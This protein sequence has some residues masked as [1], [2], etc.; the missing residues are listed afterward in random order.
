M[1]SVDLSS[2]GELIVRVNDKEKLKLLKV[3]D[4]REP[5]S[6]AFR[7]W[8][9]CEYPVLPQ[10]TSHSW[11]V[12]SSS[13]LEKPRFVVIWFQTDRKNNLLNHSAYFDH[14]YLKNL[15]VYLNS[16]VYPYEDF[17]ADFSNN[18]ISIIYKA[19]TYIDMIR[20]I[21]LKL[22]L[23]SNPIFKNLLP[24]KSIPNILE[25]ISSL[26]FMGATY[27]YYDFLNMAALLCNDPAIANK[28]KH[29][30]DLKINTM[31][32]THRLILV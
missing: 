25:S 5:L 21:S 11:T 29:T 23:G 24:T 20:I 6:C 15:K 30:T 8:N 14:C 16:E 17:H 18:Q 9:L 13:L 31:N 1:F 10:I 26:G 7:N 27:M 32:S 12:K 2:I 19:Y 28:K 22:S 3:L 4:F